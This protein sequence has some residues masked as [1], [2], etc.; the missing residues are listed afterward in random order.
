MSLFS[1]ID[2]IFIEETPGGN[3]IAKFINLNRKNEPELPIPG[4]KRYCQA[5]GRFRKLIVE[6]TGSRIEAKRFLLD[7]DISEIRE[8]KLSPKPLVSSV[9]NVKKSLP[10]KAEKIKKSGMSEENREKA[11]QRMKLY[12]EKK[13]LIGKE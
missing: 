11:S 6:T 12:H 9:E 1:D 3:R 7:I 8:V 10:P 2:K 13:K 4:L 5:N